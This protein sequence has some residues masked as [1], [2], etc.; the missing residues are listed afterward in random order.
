VANPGFAP[1]TLTGT[2]VSGDFGLTNDCGSSVA[3]QATCSLSVTWSPTGAGPQSGILT[4]TDDATD[5]P[6]VVLLIGKG[7]NGN[8]H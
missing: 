4:I 5:S 8:K 6:Q 2:S 3:A 1:V 7:N